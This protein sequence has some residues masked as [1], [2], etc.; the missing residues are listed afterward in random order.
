ML[1][2]GTERGRPIIHYLMGKRITRNHR[3]TGNFFPPRVKK[4]KEIISGFCSLERSAA[5]A[6]TR[7]T[8]A[9]AAAT[10]TTETAT[11]STT[12]A[13]TTATATATMTTTAMS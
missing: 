9:T 6:T 4:K 10:E 12:T 8:A 11:T 1:I 3:K 13:A 2:P 5:T 7:V